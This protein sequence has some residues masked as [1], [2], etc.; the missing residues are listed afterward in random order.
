[1][2]HVIVSAFALVWLGV[3]LHAVGQAA[4][5]TEPDVYRSGNGI[6]MPRLLK[7][8]K[9]QYT[10]E[11]LDAKIQGVVLLEAVVQTD[12]TVRDDVKVVRSLDMKYGLDEQAMKA[13]RQWLFVPGVR[14]RDKK[15]VAVL[16][17]IEI[18][19]T[20]ERPNRQK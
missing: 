19:F 18:A 8:V 5:Q 20:L 9:P 7:E 4:D 10:K 6:E 11:A 17:T 1:M 12:G 14:N 13:A 2:R 3:S 16:V 15:P